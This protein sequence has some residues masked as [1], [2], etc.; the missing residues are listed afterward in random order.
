MKDFTWFDVIDL[1][2]LLKKQKDRW[3]N[4]NGKY[5]VDVKTQ[6]FSLV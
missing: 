4:S 1:F 5:F 6:V 2:V 3:L